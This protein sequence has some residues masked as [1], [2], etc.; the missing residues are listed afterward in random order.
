MW[1]KKFTFKADKAD[2][3][4]GELSI[5]IPSKAEWE[6]TMLAKLK[7]E[8]LPEMPGTLSYQSEPV[9]I[10]NVGP[11]WKLYIKLEQEVT[12]LELFV[13]PSL[14]PV[15]KPKLGVGEER[16]QLV[17]SAKVKENRVVLIGWMGQ[18]EVVKVMEFI[19]A[20]VRVKEEEQ[21]P[22]QQPSDKQVTDEEISDVQ[23]SLIR[24]KD[25][26]DANEVMSIKVSMK[27]DADVVGDK[28]KLSTGQYIALNGRVFKANT[29]EDLIFLHK[30]QMEG[31]KLWFEG[32]ANGK[33]VKSNEEE[34]EKGEQEWIEPPQEKVE[35]GDEKCTIARGK[36]F[37][38]DN[39]GAPSF[40][41]EIECN[42]DVTEGKV[43]L[44]GTSQIFTF[45]DAVFK[46]GDLRDLIGM[47]IESMRGRSLWFEGKATDTGTAIKSNVVTIE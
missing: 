13:P 16:T 31:R 12:S 19:P 22:A 21:R 18:Q 3:E 46:A 24:G 25:E 4:G 39:G 35:E 2:G 38:S 15:A 11:G 36:D 47:Q 1:E 44:S 8:N 43:G 5:T 28:V 17:S 42:V 33:V 32:T 29:E 10:K 9:S 34:I 30:K 45:G 23:C 14:K 41:I 27:C 40:Q 20:N 26:E 37:P 7:G 6:A